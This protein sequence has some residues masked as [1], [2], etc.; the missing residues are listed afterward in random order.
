MSPN[1]L[2]RDHVALEAAFLTQCCHTS[3]DDLAEA[4]TESRPP[5]GESIMALS[6]PLRRSS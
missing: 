2:V 1:T 6:N 4:P 5:A 3:P